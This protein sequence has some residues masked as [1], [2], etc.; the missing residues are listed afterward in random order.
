VSA[1]AGRVESINRSSGGVPKMAV[2]EARVTFDGVEGDRQQDTINH[3]GPDRAVVLFSHDL[4][5]ALRREGH[6]IDSG[7]IGEN[8]TLSGVDWV[9][10]TPGVRLDIGEVQLQVT[11]FAAPCAKIS[12]AFLG[13]DFSRVSA[14]THAGWS[15]VC[16]R[17]LRGGTVRRGDPALMS[18]A[19]IGLTR[20]DRQGSV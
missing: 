13:G 1:K 19:V 2:G 8:L 14:T 16:A 5:Q 15:R 17:V 6:P 11:R 10:V 4:I 9:A 18:D 12:S 3:G 20:D 7:M